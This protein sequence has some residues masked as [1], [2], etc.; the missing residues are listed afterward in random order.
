MYVEFLS[1]DYAAA[2]LAEHSQPDAALTAQLEKHSRS[3]QLCLYSLLDIMIHYENAS[4]SQIVKTLENFGFTDS[5]AVKA[6]YTYIVQDPC[7]YL[8]YYLGYLEILSLQ[9]KAKEL[10]QSKYTDLRFHTFYLDCG[11]SDF[12][13]LEEKLLSAP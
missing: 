8:K 11:P 13:T 10:W 1:Y 4:Y 2:L 9:Q 5:S 12:T 3:L 6:I 7:N